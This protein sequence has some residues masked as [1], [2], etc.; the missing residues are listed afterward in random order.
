M[1]IVRRNWSFDSNS[2]WVSLRPEAYVF[3]NQGWDAN[4]AWG[5]FGYW[6]RVVAHSG[7]PKRTFHSLRQATL[8][9]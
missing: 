8:R 1:S 2:A 4:L 3:S 7:L 9:R 5:F 6:H